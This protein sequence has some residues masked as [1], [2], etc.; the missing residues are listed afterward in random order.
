M[1]T[2]LGTAFFGMIVGGL[3]F[4]VTGFAIF[5]S[6]SQVEQAAVAAR[7]PTPQ[8]PPAQIAQLM[9]RR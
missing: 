2:K 6:I 1:P 4:L 7:H 9:P 5:L 3:T 8:T